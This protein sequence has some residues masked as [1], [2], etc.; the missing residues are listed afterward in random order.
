MSK[1]FEV[2]NK[3]T[4]DVIACDWQNAF[5]LVNHGY[6]EWAKGDGRREFVAAQK[7]ARN[8]PAP[9]GFDRSVEL[10]D[11]PEDDDDLV[12]VVAPRTAAPAPVVPEVTVAQVAAQKTAAVIVTETLEDMT[13]EELFATAEKIGLTIDK[14]TGTKNLISAIRAEQEAE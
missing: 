12:P 5:E 9:E 14:R 3:A 8:L 2:R 4:G 10:D 6:W 7:L 11:A 13:R 1:N